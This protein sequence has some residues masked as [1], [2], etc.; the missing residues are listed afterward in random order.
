MDNPFDFFRMREK[1]EIQR[2]FRMADPVQ[3]ALAT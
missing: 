2:A 3:Q 1:Y